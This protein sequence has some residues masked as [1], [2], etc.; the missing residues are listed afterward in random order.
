MLPA[1]TQSCDP[2]SSGQQFPIATDPF[3]HPMSI[4]WGDRLFSKMHYPSSHAGSPVT[5]RQRHLEQGVRP[6]EAPPTF[7]EERIDRPRHGCLPEHSLMLREYGVD[8]LLVDRGRSITASEQLK[9]SPRSFSMPTGARRSRARAAVR[10]ARQQG[11]NS[12]S[13]QRTRRLTYSGAKRQDHDT[14]R[15]A[16]GSSLPHY[17]H[18]DSS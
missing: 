9:S 15:S 14:R 1:C 3:A 5:T 17:G 10:A 4:Y 6:T 7:K 11:G 2:L 18:A 13:A 16:P 8:L 12:G